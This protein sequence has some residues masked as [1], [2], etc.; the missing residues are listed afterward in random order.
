MEL[1]GMR[2]EEGGREGERKGE[3]CDTNR[4]ACGICGG[5]GRP[6]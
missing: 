4:R 6:Q 1:K 3:S 5:V 2:K